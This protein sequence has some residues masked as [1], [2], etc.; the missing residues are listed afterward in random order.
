[1]QST[2]LVQERSKP[3]SPKNIASWRRSQDEAIQYAAFRYL[4]NTWGKKWP[5]AKVYDLIFLGVNA[6]SN[7]V[8]AKLTKRLERDGFSVGLDD[9]P[10]R[11]ERILF[12]LMHCK[13]LSST[14][15][16]LRAEVGH[17]RAYDPTK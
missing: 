14:R 10:E 16:Q 7:P 13:W 11:T 12:A 3:A 9:A 6:D 4:F 2:G 1:T 8:I 17:H 5:R 15:V